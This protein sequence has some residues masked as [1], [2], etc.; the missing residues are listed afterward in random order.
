MTAPVE[1][2]VANGTVATVVASAVV[3]AVLGYASDHVTA[4]HQL[5]T[6]GAGPVVSGVLIALVAGTATFAVGYMSKHAPREL[7]QDIRSAYGQPDF[8][9]PRPATDTQSSETSDPVTA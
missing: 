3:S 7:V 8:D 1:P 4:L 6:G 9:I 2:K 5:L